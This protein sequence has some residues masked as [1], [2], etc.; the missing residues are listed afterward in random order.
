M[1]ERDISLYF[2][3]QFSCLRQERSFASDWPGDETVKILGERALPLFIAAATLSRFIR[4]V[5]WNPKKRL[6]AILTDQ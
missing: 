4:D 1:I 2:E 3:D 6:E 5:N